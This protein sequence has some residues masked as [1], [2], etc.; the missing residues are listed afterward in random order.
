MSEERKMYPIMR[1]PSVPWEVM[2]P[3]EDMAI[4][5]HSQTLA[6]LAERGGLGPEEAWMIIKGIKWRNRESEVNLKTYH[7][8]WCEY[9]E[10]INLHYEELSN[11]RKENEELHK[12][13]Q[14]ILKDQNDEPAPLEALMPV[15][16]GQEG[17]VKKSTIWELCLEVDDL[18]DELAKSKDAFAYTLLE[19]SLSL[20]KAV[21]ERD[22]LI[23]LLS[24][25]LVQ[26][27]TVKN[28]WGGPD[29][30]DLS[31]KSQAL[32]DKINKETKNENY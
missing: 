24:R 3:H 9:A 13:V 16:K 20:H 27:K 30:E 23:T 15:G 1:G 25:I 32:L 26:M 31:L 6:R 12:Q 21:D 7:Q 18:K 19:M 11:L 4:E 28:V 22:E 29:W 8:K 14:E 5:N 17:K 10:Q 2:A